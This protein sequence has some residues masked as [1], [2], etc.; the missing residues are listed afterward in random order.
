MIRRILAPLGLAA[1]LLGLAVP[2][3]SAAPSRGPKAGV[4]VTIGSP[5]R[6]TYV[7][8]TRVNTRQVRTLR[9]ELRVLESRLAQ[10]EAR[11]SRELRRRGGR[12]LERSLRADIA[13]LKVQISRAQLKLDVAL[14]RS[15]GF[16]RPVAWR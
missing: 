12:A 3:A 5:A 11:L 10:K 9:A 4:T 15:G 1:L 13:T 7:S 2:A 14:G 6:H 8:T 16:W